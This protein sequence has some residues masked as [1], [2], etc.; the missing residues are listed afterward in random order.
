VG[1]KLLPVGLTTACEVNQ[2]NLV[3]RR[4]TLIVV[5]LFPSSIECNTTDKYVMEMQSTV[6]GG[7]N[8]TKGKQNDFGICSYDPLTQ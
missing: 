2:W 4:T 3:G 6:D 7:C 8:L 1:L 5:A